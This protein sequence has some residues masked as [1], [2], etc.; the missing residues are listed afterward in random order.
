M[1]GE[2]AEE[3]TYSVIFRSLKHPIRRK[4]LRM[5]ANRPMSFSEILEGV[6]I[7]SGHMTY[8]LESLGELIIR[9]SDGRYA[10]SSIGT[11]AMK[12]M[13]GVEE[14]VEEKTAPVIP[15]SKKQAILMIVSVGLLVS[16]L[17]PFSLFACQYTLSTIV[18]ERTSYVQI[19]A[20]QTFTHNFTVVY[21]DTISIRVSNVSDNPTEIPVEQL[22]FPFESFDNQSTYFMRQMPIKT[23]T[24]W[25]EDYAVFR[26][27]IHEGDY[28]S[29]RVYNSEGELL[30]NESRRAVYI[31]DL[32]SISKIWVKVTEYG[33]MRWIGENGDPREIPRT[34][35][36]ILDRP[37]VIDRTFKFELDAIHS[38]QT[39]SATLTVGLRHESFTKPYYYYG[40]VGLLIAVICPTLMLVSRLLTKR[41]P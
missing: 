18:W 38:N 36:L 10:L 24:Y 14:G 13:G 1:V 34:D 11:A 32:T 3:E 29:Y 4:I 35:M 22:K 8:H 27:K 17:I 15:P 23:T 28:V 40:I 26:L 33:D 2:E 19:P 41:K 37:L 30:L 31:I 9:T 5:L 25:E 21:V 7:D 12:L 6:T 20:N 39:Y 16:A